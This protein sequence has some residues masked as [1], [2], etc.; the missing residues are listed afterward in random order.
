MSFPKRI[1]AGSLFLAAVLMM[2]VAMSG[3][4]SACACG[5]FRGVV[6]A[7]GTSPNGMWWRIKATRLHHKGQEDRLLVHF[8]YGEPEAEGGYFSEMPLPVPPK[9]VLTADSGGGDEEN[10]QR[11]ISGITAARAVELQVEMNDGEVL[12]VRPE[13]PPRSL[14]RRF[15]WLH[16]LRFF[17]AFYSAPEEPRLVKAFDQSGHIL[18]RSKAQGGLFFI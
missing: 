10:P 13:L 2:L 8:S 9:F 7:H 17:D 14:R 1:S 3:G 12:V 11:D 18:G 5:E 4:A 16:G 6:V 15:G